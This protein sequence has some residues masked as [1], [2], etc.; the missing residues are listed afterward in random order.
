MPSLITCARPWS[1]R[2]AGPADRPHQQLVPQAADHHRLAAVQPLAAR[3]GRHRRCSTALSAV[4]TN[5]SPHRRWLISGTAADGPVA[6]LR[7]EA[8]LPADEATASVLTKL[9]RRHRGGPELRSR[10]RSSSSTAALQ[11]RV[12]SQRAPR[13]RTPETRW[14]SLHVRRTQHHGHPHSKRGSSTPEF[15]SRRAY[16][17]SQRVDLRECR[18]PRMPTSQRSVPVQLA[19]SRRLITYG[20]DGVVGP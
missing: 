3:H 20:S 10:P 15:R 12:G 17:I 16:A 5:C 2:G 8:F 4:P 9:G 7:R 19:G 6:E 11:Q 14:S 1:Q 18:R 13:P